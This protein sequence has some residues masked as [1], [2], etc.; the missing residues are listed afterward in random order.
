VTQ[1]KVEDNIEKEAAVANQGAV[2]VVG[3]DG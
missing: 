2:V 1:E 3:Q